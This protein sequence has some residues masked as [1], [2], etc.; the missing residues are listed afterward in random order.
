MFRAA[1][2]DIDASEG[3]VKCG[4]CRKVFD[5]RKN[6]IK[7]ADFVKPDEPDI[8]ETTSEDPVSVTDD[9]DTSPEHDEFVPQISL[10]EESEQLDKSI[11]GENKE[12]GSVSAAGK[13]FSTDD[14][15][16]SVK[17]AS[18]AEYQSSATE[19]KTKSHPANRDEHSAN[20]NVNKNKLR[21]S[22]VQKR[23]QAAGKRT[24]DVPGFGQI[25]AENKQRHP[26]ILKNRLNIAKPQA[27]GFSRVIV[28]KAQSWKK[29]KKR[30]K[31]TGAFPYVII[32]VTLFALFIW[33]ITVVNYN[34]LSQ[35]G[36]M[37]APM[38]AICSIVTCN[39]TAQLKGPGF[40]I[41]HAS[42]RRHASIPNVMSVS[43]KLINFSDENKLM[44]TL[45]LDLKNDENKV[46]ASRI[47]DLKDNPQF[48]DPALTELAPGQDVQLLFNIENPGKSAHGFQLNLVSTINPAS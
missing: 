5:C 32:A 46:I 27:P 25:K 42:I 38:A 6:E 24:V 37:S 34:K 36:F 23:P 35:Y 10:F 8:D 22:T 9:E 7:P 20:P 26:S 2:S 47:I 48:V 30:S 39:Q 28:A 29:Q 15:G 4:H 12:S 41:L 17:P 1:V 13:P 18:P 31:K 33:Q 40:E 43:A 16:T 21:T 44:P 45:R 3:W 11:A 19:A 14:Q